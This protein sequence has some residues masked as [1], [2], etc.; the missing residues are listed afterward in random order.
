MDCHTFNSLLHEYLDDALDAGRRDAVRLHLGQCGA[1][2]QAL[3]REEVLS[4]SIRQSLDQATAHLSVR[5]GMGP[6]VLRALESEPSRWL[7]WMA[8][9]RSLAAIRPAGAVAAAMGVALF[10][11]CIQFYRHGAGRPELNMAGSGRGTCVVNVPLPAR[12]HEFRMQGDIVVDSISDEAGIADAR[13][14]EGSDQSSTK[15]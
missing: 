10:L 7:A 15:P 4:N 3:A 12:T 2:R 1:C 13:I 11:L 5:P 9:V 6:R 8:A 14:S